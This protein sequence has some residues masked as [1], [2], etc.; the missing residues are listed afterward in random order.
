MADSDI[1]ADRDAFETIALG[2]TGEVRTYERTADTTDIPAE[3]V[4]VGPAIPAEVMAVLRNMNLGYPDVVL[5]LIAA[6]VLH[7]ARPLWLAE[8]DA[9]LRDEAESWRTAGDEYAQSTRDERAARYEMSAAF[10]RLRY[11]DVL[12]ADR[13]Q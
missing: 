9:A 2:V 13:G 7:A 1:P 4:E 12:G 6:R 11:E 8:V 5:G 3:A 10:L